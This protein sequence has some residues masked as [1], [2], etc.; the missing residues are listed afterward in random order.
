MR[1]NMTTQK[2]A[3]STWNTIAEMLRLFTPV[4]LS[5]LAYL[6]IGFQNILLDNTKSITAL[7]IQMAQITEQLK[8]LEKTDNNFDDRIRKL[9]DVAVENRR[10]ISILEEYNKPQQRR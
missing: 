10:R 1:S 3:S 8:T 4:L 5:L 9:E 2:Q 7:Q 6:F